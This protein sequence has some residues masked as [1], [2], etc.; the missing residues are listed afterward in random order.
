MIKVIDKTLKKIT[1]TGPTLECIDESV[2]IEGLGAQKIGKTP[3]QRSPIIINKNLLQRKNSGEKHDQR[4]I[5]IYNFIEKLD[6]KE[7]EDFFCFKSG[8]EGDNGEHLMY[9]LDMYF[10]NKSN[11]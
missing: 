11:S 1:V 3:K 2:I 5:E 10:E 9:L 4:S 6:F 8:G 7:G